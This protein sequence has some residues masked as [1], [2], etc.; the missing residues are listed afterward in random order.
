M[1]TAYETVPPVY[2]PVR[3]PARQ[4]VDPMRALVLPRLLGIKASGGGF[5]ARCPAHDDNSP[6][7]SVKAGHTHPV[8]FTCHA[9][10]SPDDIL[11]S[12]GLSWSDLSAPREQS[13]SSDDYMRC[14]W[15]KATGSHDWRHRKVAEYPYRDSLGNLA[16]A[17]ARCALKGV[18]DSSGN[19]LC[20]GFRQWRPDPTSRSGKRWH[21]NLPDGTRVGEDLIYRL[22]EVIAAADAARTVYITEGEKDANA[23]WSAGYAATCSPQGACKWKQPHSQW[24][25]GADVIIVADRDDAGWRHAEVVTNSLL[26]G[27]RSIEIVRAASGKDAFDHLAAGLPVTRLVTVAMPK[28]APSIGPDG[29]DVGCS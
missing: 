10:C 17:V 2:T 12:L 29:V 21:R 5:T 9:G 18:K 27:A 11:A 19:T 20:Q 22:P 6:S 14:G 26:P 3:Q 7:L 25:K 23:L 15:N 8:V 28:P 1:T 13:H 24:L 16:F 4:A